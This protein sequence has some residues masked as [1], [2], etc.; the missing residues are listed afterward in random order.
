MQGEIGEVSTASVA[1]GV[2]GVAGNKGAVAVSFTLNRRR[3]VCICSHFAAHSVND[4]PHFFQPVQGFRVLP[5]TAGQ[6]FGSED[7]LEEFSA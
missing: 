1:C 6:A 3:V 4:L 7:M 2:M 5:A